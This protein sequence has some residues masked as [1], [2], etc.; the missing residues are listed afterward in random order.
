MFRLA[1]LLYN[2]ILPLGFIV[3][4]PGLIYKL[5]ARPGGRRHLWSVSVVLAGVKMS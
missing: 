5:I 2:L 1:M 3:F 4:L